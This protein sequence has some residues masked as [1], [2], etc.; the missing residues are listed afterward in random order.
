M[1]ALTM[2]EFNLAVLRPVTVFTGRVMGTPA[3]PYVSLSWDG[4]AT[5]TASGIGTS[6]APVAGCTV[7]FGSSAGARDRGVTRVR[8]WT[9]NGPT[10]PATG[11]L[12]IAET[13]DVGP[14]IQDNDYITILLEFRP[15]PKNP[16][17][18]QSGDI[19]TF[20]EDYDIAYSDQTQNWYPVAN[21]GP[22]AF[23]EISNSSGTVQFVGNQST[24]MAPGATLSS[25]LW[26]AHGSVEGTSTSQGTPGSPVE[27]NWTSAGQYLVSLKVTDSNGETH[28]NYTWAFISDGDQTNDNA[29][30]YLDF[31]AINDSFDWQGGGGECTFTVHG[32]ADI[33]EFPREAMIVHAISKGSLTQGS[34]GSWHNREN[35]LFVGYIAENTIN[36][37]SEHD[38]VTF[39]A[40][41][42]DKL[43]NNIKSFPIS[44]TDAASP[45]DWVEGVD[46]TADRL[47]SYLFK[48]R[49]TIDTMTPIVFSGYTPE[50]YRQNV[51]PTT[52][53]QQAQSEI[54]RDIWGRL[55]VNHQGVLYFEIEYNHMLS[56]ERSGQPSGGFTLQKGI[57]ASQ[58]SINERHEWILPAS[59]AKSSGVAY[60]GGA[61]PNNATPLFSEA[62]GQDVPKSYGREIGH[63]RYVLNNQSDLNTRCGYEL[64]RA[65]IRFPAYRMTFY[66]YGAFTVAPQTTFTSNIEAADNNRQFTG[67]PT[68]V[69]KRVRRSYDHALGFVR[70]DVDFEPDTT[71]PAGETVVMPATPPETQYPDPP[72]PEWE[73]IDVAIVVW[74]PEGSTYY[75][76][77]GDDSNWESRDAGLSGPQLLDYFGGVDPFWWTFV[78][79]DSYNPDGAIFFKSYA[80]A[81]L[82]T[83]NAGKTSWGDV[84]PTGTPAAAQMVSIDSNIFTNQEHYFTIRNASGTDWQSFIIKTADD[85]STYVWAEI[86]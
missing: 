17:V 81:L 69:P 53:L 72:A 31:D 76:G 35:I 59:K 42:I 74:K 65:N 56:S 12:E 20:F 75:H 62:P 34:A 54:A 67:T 1:T 41:T 73:P 84:T 77:L 57:W 14:Q 78:K 10:D 45:S 80:G 7:F 66:N 38:S 44:L 33:T 15:Q 68:L 40:V 58:I 36:Q 79:K 6:G 61:D 2:L 50:I 9:P 16:R 21:A 19:I 47:M 29:P 52:L 30:I 39:R 49:S 46:L 24:A 3:S 70:I 8:S 37:A 60:S 32:E 27:F 25:Y 4:G 23:A 85:G 86:T 5:G 71:G 11:T 18:T 51:G 28:T 82:R 13:D 26:T 22:P 83:T 48:W 64:A 63:A 43:M 55:V